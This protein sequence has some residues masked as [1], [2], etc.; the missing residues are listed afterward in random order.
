MGRPLNKSE[1]AALEAMASRTS[2]WAILQW[3]GERV[4]NAAIA[5]GRL[6]GKLAGERM[7]ALADHIKDF[8][9][10]QEPR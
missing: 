8:P 6:G 10:G 4:S 5:A 7:Q 2:L 9:P 3:C 1:L